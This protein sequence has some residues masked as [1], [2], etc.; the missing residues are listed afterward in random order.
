NRMLGVRRPAIQ[1]ISQIVAVR[2]FEIA[3]ANSDQTEA[4]SPDFMREEIA[5]C[6]KD[7]RG[8]LGRRAESTR[9]RADLEV[10]A[11]EFQRYGRAGERI[12]LESA[13][14]AFSQFPQ[15][16]LQ[17]PK[18]ADVALEGGFRRNAFCVALG[19]DGALVYSAGE[20]P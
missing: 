6:G 10:S 3:D 19:V 1:K 9:P 4:G 12:G 16:L 2:V 11:L 14:D 7:A 5:A 8:E 17:R 15:M 20:L 18:L 13:R